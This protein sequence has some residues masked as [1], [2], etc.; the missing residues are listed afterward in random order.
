MQDYY[1]AAKSISRLNEISL[2]ILEQKILNRTRR[3]SEQISSFEIINNLIGLKKNIT[4][5]DNPSLLLEIFLQFQKNKNIKGIQSETINQI[6]E[7]LDLINNSFSRGL[8]F[9]LMGTYIN[10][11]WSNTFYLRNNYN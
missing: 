7:S 1:K 6:I 9:L 8:Y 10:Y 4:F 5:A 2:Q 3:K 11:Y